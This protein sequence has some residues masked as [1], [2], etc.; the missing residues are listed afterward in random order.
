MYL[1]FSQ[2]EKEKEKRKALYE[3]V[4]GEAS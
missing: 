3:E 4:G 2:K 1:P